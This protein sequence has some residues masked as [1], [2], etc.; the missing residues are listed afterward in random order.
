VETTVL[1][2]TVQV[3][4]VLVLR[5]VMVLTATQVVMADLDLQQIYELVVMKLMVVVEAVVPISLVL[6]LVLEAPAVAAMAEKVIQE[7][8]ET[9]RPV[10]AAVAVEDHRQHF[11]VVQADLV[12]LLFVI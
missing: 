9:M 7:L 8:L 10:V 5:V 11:T 1:V 12:S 4:A 6:L 3:V 2:R